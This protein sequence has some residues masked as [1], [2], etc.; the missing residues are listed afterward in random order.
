VT[1]PSI[2]RL[3]DV[4]RLSGFD[5]SEGELEPLRPAVTAA[6]AALARLERPP[7]AGVEPTTTY[8]VIQ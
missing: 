8:R 2:E 1:G 7:I 6:L 4:A 3:A 5:W